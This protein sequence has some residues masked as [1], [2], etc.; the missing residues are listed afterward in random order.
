MV[1]DSNE[2]FEATSFLT[3]HGNKIEESDKQY[4]VTNIEFEAMV[5][6]IK[7]YVFYQRIV[8]F[9]NKLELNDQKYQTNGNVRDENY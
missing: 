8:D 4:M 6:L 7:N 3:F 2:D 1:V 9:V 5:T